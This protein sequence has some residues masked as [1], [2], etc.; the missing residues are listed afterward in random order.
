MEAPTLPDRPTA[1]TVRPEGIP[2]EMKGLRQWVNWRQVP[3]GNKWTKPPFQPDGRPAKSDDPSTW[4]TFK[5]VLRSYQDGNWDGIGFVFSADDQYFGIDRDHIYDGAAPHSSR[6]DLIRDFGTY[7]ETSPSGTGDHLLCRGVL[8][9]GRTG[10]RRGP[11][12]VYSS[13]RFFTVTGHRIEGAATTIEQNDLALARF[14]KQHIDRPDPQPADAA[15]LPRPPMSLDE[16]EILRLVRKSRIGADFEALWS[17]DISKYGTDQSRADLALLGY[18]RFYSQDAAVLESLFGQ[19]ALGQR[20]KWRDRLDYRTRT[21]ERVLEDGGETYSGP[22]RARPTEDDAPD[23]ATVFVGDGAGPGK[24]SQAAEAITLCEDAGD[25]FWH[26]PTGDVFATVQIAGHRENLI[27]NGKAYKELI[28]HRVWLALGKSIGGA[29]LQDAVNTLAGKARF[30]GDEYAIANRIAHLDGQTWVDLGTPDWTALRIGAD[31]WEILA[32]VDAPVMFRRTSTTAPL[33]VPEAG[34]DLDELREQFDIDD[35]DWKRAIAWLI[36]VFLR[37]G[38]RPILEIVGR[39]GSGKSTFAR[40]LM[41]LGDPQRVPLRS[42]PRDEAALTIAAQ[43]RAANGYDNLSHFTG[44]IADVLCRAVTGGGMGSRRLY[45]ND[46]EVVLDIHISLL[47]TAITPLT[48]S[49]PDLADRTMTIRLNAL[50]DLDYRSERVIWEAFEEMRPRLYGALCQAIVV[51]LRRQGTFVL[52]RRPRMADFAEFVEAAAPALGWQP[53]EFI[54]L[55]EVSRSDANLLAM[56]A[57]PVALLIVDLVDELG[58]W[59]GT[60]ADL[61]E[62]LRQRAN[63]DIRH[64]RGFPKKPNTLSAHLSRIEPVLSNVGVTVTMGRTAA[65]R[66]ITLSR[67]DPAPSH[68]GD[69][70]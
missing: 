16:H 49:R 59:H 62:V 30:E 36:G 61:L 42:L 46:E 63:E 55:L 51:A 28:A 22:R 3:R 57:S 38:G 48:V 31:G 23:T 8:P 11:F 41:S 32:S 14:L 45:S 18:L 29:S 17:G 70:W 34:G 4:S 9:G 39:Q 69:L 20:E 40:M 19:S 15:S 24:R 44:E 2:D 67:S 64:D 50:T 33:P 6:D 37:E 35:S 26:T 43:G 1:L 27:I 68:E 65:S 13:G 56:E 25:R 5:D 54:D 52:N 12:E 66:T 10:G 53:G 60:P 7:A 21:I 58:P 47:W